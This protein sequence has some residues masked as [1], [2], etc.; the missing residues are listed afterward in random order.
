MA[1]RT[2][3][4]AGGAY[5]EVEI[6]ALPGLGTSWHRRSVGYWLRRTTTGLLW[7]ALLSGLYA[8]TLAMYAGFFDEVSGTVRTLVNAVLGVAS[9][10]GLVWGWVAQ[11]RRH[12]KALLD[13]PT[14]DQTWTAKR[15][16]ARRNVGVTFGW[17]SAI[18]LAVPVLPAL[19]AYTIGELLGVLTVRE[20]AAEAGARRW[21]ETA[22]TARPSG[23]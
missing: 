19:M 13:P 2:S 8:A 9:C 4:E 21:L 22:S 7:L 18:I 20:S 5:A 10:A 15:L 23:G 14:P 3:S 12:R 11:R 1:S 6:P 17:R 16:R